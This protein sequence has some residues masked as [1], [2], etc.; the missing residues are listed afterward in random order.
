MR[1]NELFT[2][3]NA[4]GIHRT[5][6]SGNSAFDPNHGSVGEQPAFFDQWAAFYNKYYV[7]SSKIRVQIMNTSSTVPFRFTI[8]PST[9]STL[10]TT[11]DLM[12]LPYSKTKLV[13]GDIATWGN[14]SMKHYM[15]A[16]KVFGTRTDQELNYQGNM[17]GSDP[18]T[19][20]YWAL[21]AEAL[22]GIS[23][24]NYHI[25]VQV[26]YYIRLSNRVNV[27]ES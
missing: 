4:T 16:N 11:V 19:E 21:V 2:I 20:W 22:D 8:L 26:T 18:A 1:Y 25:Q 3:T 23:D 13:S 15:T 9:S 27:N 7:A 6:M 12:D 24:L 10:A 5:W 14:R 17:S